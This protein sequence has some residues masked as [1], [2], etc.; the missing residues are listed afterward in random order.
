MAIAKRCAYFPNKQLRMNL[1][2]KREAW[3]N[4]LKTL[5]GATPDPSLRVVLLAA[6]PD[7]ETIGASALLAK[8]PQTYVV[9]LTDVALLDAKSLSSDV[10]YSPEEYA[11]MR[12]A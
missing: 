11:A 5:K 6:H 3:R 2:A 10:L 12:Q 4:T 8:V 1:Q 7:D 9:Y